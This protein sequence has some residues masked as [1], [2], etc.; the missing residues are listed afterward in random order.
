MSQFGQTVLNQAIYTPLST[1][2][3]LTPESSAQLMPCVNKIISVVPTNASS[4]GPSGMLT[5]NLGNQ[6]WIKNGTAVLKFSLSVAQAAN[7]YQ[8]A[9]V[10]S[11]ASLLAR[12]TIQAGSNQIEQI[13]HYYIY[14]ALIMAHA[15]SQDYFAYDA[16][17]TDG[18]G[19]TDYAGAT[20][21]NFCIPLVSGTFYNSAGKHFPSFLLSSPLQV[22]IDTNTLNL[23]FQAAT[24]AITNYTISNVALMYEQLSTDE[25]FNN[26]IRN[27][28]LTGGK[29]WSI[30]FQSVQ[31]VSTSASGAGTVSFTSGVSNSSLDGIIVTGTTS[32]LTATTGAKVFN[33]DAANAIT[34][35]EY[36]VDGLKHIQYNL[37]TAPVQFLELQRT[38]GNIFST[39]DTSISTLTTY[40]STYWATGCS[41][42]RVKDVNTMEGIP[43]NNVMVQLTGPA[44]ANTTW[45]FFLYSGTIKID[46][47]GG[48]LVSK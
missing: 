37:D 28:L 46:G 17:I 6:G 8:F 5:F 13:N 9:W 20:T 2:L 44:A 33:L 48:V 29:V 19:K 1:P 47:L 41:L 10:G 42:R 32:T 39:T 15:T 25:S 45:F 16:T 23:S 26:T 40:L 22:V 27:E 30:P 12:L 14:Y 36:Y 18:C 38:L 24:T 35:V 3:S 21:Y 43:A 4:A 31:A 34:N 7:D 11:V